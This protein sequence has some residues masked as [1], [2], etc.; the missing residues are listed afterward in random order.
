MAWSFNLYTHASVETIPI[1]PLVS[2][3]QAVY[4]KINTQAFWSKANSR[5][6]KYLKGSSEDWRMSME[7]ISG[8]PSFHMIY[9]RFFLFF[10]FFFCIKSNFL[11]NGL[12][13]GNAEEKLKSIAIIWALKCIR[14]YI[15]LEWLR[16]KYI[17]L[18]DSYIF[19]CI[20]S[21]KKDKYK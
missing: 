17:Y 1:L 14:T 19:L 7:E 21:T 5:S 13:R 8:F 20:A 16:K 12:P 3:Q 6:F 18:R 4:H 2:D 10:L 15:F 9:L 11:R